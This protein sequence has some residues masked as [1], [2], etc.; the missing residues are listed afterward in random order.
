MRTPNQITLKIR[1]RTQN[2]MRKIR[3]DIQLK[4]VFNEGRKE[5]RNHFEMNTLTLKM[6]RGLMKKWTRHL[7]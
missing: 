3:K 5:R 2:L 7:P 4:L 1:K 6:Q